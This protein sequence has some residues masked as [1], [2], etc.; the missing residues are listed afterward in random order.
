MCFGFLNIRR[1]NLLQVPRADG[2]GDGDSFSLFPS[3]FDLQ[4]MAFV[5]L[6]QLFAHRVCG[7]KLQSSPWQWQWQLQ[8]SL[9]SAPF[10]CVRCCLK[11]LRNSLNKSREERNK[12]KTGCRTDCPLP[13]AD[14]PRRP[15]IFD[16][17]PL[18]R[19]RRRRRRQPFWTQNA[20]GRWFFFRIIA[21]S[22]ST[23]G[24]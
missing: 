22:S 1:D 11:N 13:I 19:R 21:G 3:F 17:T 6:R 9:N 4:I 24:A 2:D 7:D 23:A 12:D 14:C 20:V 18:A 8:N 16:K 5:E 10:A 15:Q